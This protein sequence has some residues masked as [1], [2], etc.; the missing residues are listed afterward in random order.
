MRHFTTGYDYIDETLQDVKKELPKNLQEKLDYA[1]R[2]VHSL[3]VHVGYAQA[4]K[5]E[6][7]TEKVKK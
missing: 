3:G 6:V 5:Q 4:T 2:N 1:I 7:S